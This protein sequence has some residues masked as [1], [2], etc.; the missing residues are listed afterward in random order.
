[1]SG[2]SSQ[3]GSHRNPFLAHQSFLSFYPIQDSS[4]VQLLTWPQHC[5][6]ICFLSLKKA[7]DSEIPKVWQQPVKFPFD[8]SAIFS[9]GHL[10]G[11]GKIQSRVVWDGRPG[12]A[13]WVLNA[14]TVVQDRQPPQIKTDLWMKQSRPFISYLY[15]GRENLLSRILKEGHV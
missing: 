7:L 5:S 12:E 9:T 14:S 10:V 4:R 1:M 11:S 6:Q 8:L 13:V 3:K 15:C 2:L